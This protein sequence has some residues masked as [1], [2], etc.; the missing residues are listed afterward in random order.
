M[1]T[2]FNISVAEKCLFGIFARQ[3]SNPRQTFIRKGIWN[4][5]LAGKD[6]FCFIYTV[7]Y[8]TLKIFVSD[9]YK[10]VI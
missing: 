4:R 8:V 6:A 10:Q 3:V 9:V 2:N 7:L 5:Y 1:F